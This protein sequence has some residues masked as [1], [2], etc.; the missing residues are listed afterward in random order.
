MTREIATKHGWNTE[1]PKVLSSNNV[2]TT[3]KTLK[4]LNAIRSRLSALFELRPL[5][6]RLFAKVK[7]IYRTINVEKSKSYK[8]EEV[9]NDCTYDSYSAYN[10]IL[11]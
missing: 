4:A 9:S 7:V 6:N 3:D 1:L 10:V 5:P 2:L 11:T 8:L